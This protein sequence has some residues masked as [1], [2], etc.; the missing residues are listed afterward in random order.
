MNTSSAQQTYSITLDDPITVSSGFIAQDISSIDSSMV[1]FTGAAGS[2]VDT[3]TITGGGSGYTVGNVA[4][5]S[6]DINPSIFTWK[7][8][9]F[10]DCFPD[11]DKV[12]EMC[13]QY[14]ALDIALKKFKEVYKMVED[15]YNAQKGGKYTP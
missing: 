15:D 5:G 8:E 6:I 12:N 3:I 7:N 1:T 11:F 2:S 14:P 9:E 10:V 4:L 13:N